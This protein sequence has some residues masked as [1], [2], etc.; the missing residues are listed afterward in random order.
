MMAFLAELAVSIGLMALLGFLLFG[1]PVG[2]FLVSGA[3]LYLGVMAV[4]VIVGILM[5]MFHRD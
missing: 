1:T 5:S 3:L 4:M 2:A